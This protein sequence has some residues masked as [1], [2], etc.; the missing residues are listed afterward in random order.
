MLSEN[1]PLTELKGIGPKSAE[2]FQQLGIF[3]VA[4][5]LLYFPFRYED[6]KAR[7][8]FELQDGEKA[9]VTGTLVTPANLQYYGR[10]KNRLSFKLKQGEVV[11]SVSF[12]NQP[13]LKDKLQLGSELAIF[14][15]WDSKKTALT[16]I[17]LLAQVQEDMQPVYRLTQGV[18]QV[19]LVKAIKT[20]FESGVL[21]HLP[22]TLPQVLIDKYRLFSRKEAITAMHFPKDLAE[23]KQ[24]L[25]RVKFEELFYFQMN[26]QVLKARRKS[27]QYGLAIA[28]DEE[29]LAAKEAS[30]PFLLTGA[31]KRSLD[32]ILQDMRSQ[33]HMNRLLQG[34]V[35]SGKTAVASLAMYAAYSAGFQSAL[36][37]PTEILAE[38]HY[39]S[40]TQLFP[41]LSIAIL[42]SGMKK[43]AKDTALEQIREGSVQMIVGTHALIQENV[44]YHKLGLVITDEQHRFGVN[45]RRVLREKGKIQMF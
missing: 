41:E 17:K 20:A 27:D 11:I 36:M 29:K 13:Y 38:Q 42:T 7:S 33:S 10:Q 34:D 12:F 24:A 21:E 30:L 14:G 39:E 1:S 25:R 40:L 45:Q 37:V 4:D 16:G 6:Y 23:Y 18:T 26:L 35:G 8:V 28:Y 22:E 32:E 5:L 9:V 31:Q 3:T 44:A 2:K 43:A 15:K 19:S